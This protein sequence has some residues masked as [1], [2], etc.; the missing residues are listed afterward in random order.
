MDATPRPATGS[1]IDQVLAR[2]VNVKP[3]R[4]GWL[5]SCPHH[6]DQRPSLSVSTGKDDRV[7][8]MCH[9]GCSTD[10]VVHALGLEMPDLFP[11]HPC[12][13][14]SDGTREVATY[15]YRDEENR[16]LY[17]VVRYEP[18]DFRVRR[19]L[20]SGNNVWRL[21][22]TRRVLYRLPELLGAD[23]AEPVWIVEGEK[24]AD[25]LADL[26][27][28]A[29]TN[30]GGSGKWRP[31]YT[32]VLRGRRVRII[33]DNDE[34]GRNHA[35]RV[36]HALHGVAAEVKI[37]ALPNL[38]PKGDAGDW[39]ACG[40]T[41]DE[42]RQ[43][44]DRAMTHAPIDR[45]GEAPQPDV[46]A[47]RFQLVPIAEV[48]DRDPPK[49]L[50]DGVLLSD[51][52]AGLVGEPGTF[53]SIL[54][55]DMALSV[56]QGLDWQGHRTRRRLAIYVSGEGSGGI[57]RRLA[58]W[59]AHVGVE[60]AGCYLLP[61][62]LQL[63]EGGDVEAILA[64]ISELPERPGLIV[65]DTLARC[66]VGGDENSAKDMGRFVAAVDRLRHETGA[67][68]LLVH[69]VTWGG[70]IRG[71]TAL[72]GALDTLVEV[73]RDEDRVTLSCGKQK[74]VEE[75]SDITLAKRVVDLGRDAEGGSVTSLVL[76]RVEP[77]P[78]AKK[79][80]TSDTLALDALRPFG[81]GGARATE[82]ERSAVGP[83]L[84]RRTFYR[85]KVRLEAAG[86]VVTSGEGEETRYCVGGARCHSG[87]SEV[88]WHQDLAGVAG[89][90]VPPPLRGGTGDT[91]DLTNLAVVE[92]TALA[93]VTPDAEE[94]TVWMG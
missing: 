33:P 58:A 86:C 80:L 61:Q 50:V 37:V 59:E 23:E 38:P 76:A 22:D 2:L 35:K 60:A 56:A 89:V 74:D 32:E 69:H 34:P 41:A 10:D 24:D 25:A 15:G 75:F 73:K 81:Q 85:A 27:F 88:S 3:D 28:I 68:V 87:A 62:A 54:A 18:K 44:A 16:A 79:M 47:R 40:G 19:V 6:D 20:E 83:R 48:N 93:S 82:W 9:A 5:A 91:D 21:D 26:G 53:K 66:M 65:I 84:R 12:T 14:D 52:L 94:V 49:Y 17:E 64:A 39:L 30:V 13:T 51:T 78:R 63:L 43:L 90:T 57:G 71:S 70:R 31:E 72:L 77:S 11:Q 92:P 29:T 55:L 42:L 4:S 46:P 45:D 67:T 7:L 8:L 1:P 36:A